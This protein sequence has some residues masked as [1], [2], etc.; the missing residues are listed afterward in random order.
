MNYKTVSWERQL[1]SD[2]LNWPTL[3]GV[4]MFKSRR[5][6][7]DGHLLAPQEPGLGVELDEAA[8]D[9]YRVE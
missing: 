7:E 1:A 9:R 4:S 3:H 8:C 2:S 6:L 5:E